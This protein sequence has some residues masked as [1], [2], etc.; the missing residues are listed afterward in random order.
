MTMSIILNMQC[1]ECGGIF[2]MNQKTYIELGLTQFPKR[3]PTCLDKRQGRP[4]V[5][6]ERKQLQ[7]WKGVEVKRFPF[8]LLPFQSSIHDLPIK[9]CNIKGD[10]GQGVSWNGR[11]DVYSYLPDDNIIGKIIDIRLME[12]TRNRKV[13]EKNEHGEEVKRLIEGEKQQY[14][15][16]EPSEEQPSGMKL[17]W[18]RADYKTTLK[19]FGRQYNA[20]VDTENSIWAYQ[21]S[22][23][24]RS[25]RFGTYMAIAI[26]APGNPAR[27]IV[28]GDIQREEYFE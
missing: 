7:E 6:L 14:L 5:A 19:G 10:A 27:E 25:G 2:P 8:A 26:V 15:V 17:V 13:S 11:L 9:R 22:S 24:C 20:K 21:V 1:T 23:A 4:T 18:L 3:C 12:I 16:F 28:W